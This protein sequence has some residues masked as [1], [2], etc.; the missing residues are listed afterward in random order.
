M[1]DLFGESA[2]RVKNIDAYAA[3]PGTGPDGKRCRDCSHFI[4]VHMAK[5][6]FKCGM[7]RVSNSASTDIRATAPACRFFEGVSRYSRVEDE[8]SVL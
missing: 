8:G 7:G 3:N 2:L 5:I 1:T 4:R 6:Y